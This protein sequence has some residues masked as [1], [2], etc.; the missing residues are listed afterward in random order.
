VNDLIVCVQKDGL[1]P[2]ERSFREAGRCEEARQLRNALREVL[3]KDV[4][5]VIEELTERRVLS[6]LSDCD[7]ERDISVDC[8]VLEPSTNGGPESVAS[9]MI[10]RDQSGFPAVG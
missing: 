3:R 4:V 2:L 9:P 10:D 8:F 6:F 7:V 1:T 5:P